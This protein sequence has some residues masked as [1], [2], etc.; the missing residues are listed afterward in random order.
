MN[1]KEKN[2][3]GK[4]YVKMQQDKENNPNN[5]IDDNNILKKMEIINKNEKIQLIVRLNKKE[6]I[7]S[8]DIVLI[9]EDIVLQK[10]YYQESTKSKEIEKRYLELIDIAQNK[11]IIEILEDGKEYLENR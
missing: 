8:T 2:L 9:E 3:F 11:S 4:L 10:L 5:Y 6:K 7:I 1:S